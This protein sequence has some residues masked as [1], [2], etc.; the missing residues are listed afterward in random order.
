MMLP[1]DMSGE[2]LVGLL[3]RHYGYRV[4]RQRGSH[5]RLVTNIRGREHR[6]SVPRHSALKIGTLYSVQAI[7]LLQFQ[8]PS[9]EIAPTY[10][11]KRLSKILDVPAR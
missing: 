3:R 2:E 8:K 10:D 1:R 7:S 11:E 4:V 9:D 5:M 6:V